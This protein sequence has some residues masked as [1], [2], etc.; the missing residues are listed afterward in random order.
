VCEYDYPL[1]CVACQ[2]ANGYIQIVGFGYLANKHT[3][4]FEVFL[5][6]FKELAEEERRMGKESL[7]GFSYVTEPNLKPM[8]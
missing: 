3:E 8:P 2:D 5:K 7:Q 4:G 1:E 6:G